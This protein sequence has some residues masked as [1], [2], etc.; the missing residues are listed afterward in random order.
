MIVSDSDFIRKQWQETLTRFK[1]DEDKWE[2]HTK[3][4][5]IQKCDDLAL[6]MIENKVLD[7]EIEGISSYLFKTINDFGISVS[8]RYIR[9]VIPENHTRKY[10]KSE[11]SSELDQSVYKKIETEDPEITLEK[12]QFNDIKINGVEYRPIIKKE[13]TTIK[14]TPTKEEPKT[15]FYTYL[16]AMRKLANKFELTQK[17]L[18]DRYRNDPEARK[19][20]E[21]ELGDVEKKLQDYAQMWANIENAK[22]MIDLRRHYGEYEKIMAAFMMETGET[23]AKMAQVMEYNNVYGRVK[24]YSEKYGSI[25][26]LREPRVREFFE[27]PYTY[28]LFLRSCPKCMED[29]SPLMNRNIEYYR[30]CQSQGIEYKP[31]YIEIPTIK[32]SF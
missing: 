3:A 12:D 13:P 5:Y 10:L 27:K 20:I 6:A 23:I 29:I 17:S 11:V 19:I 32:Y 25:G 31:L 2:N 26:I 14:E 9:D 7:L 15:R 1:D 22:G 16:E 28:P 8:D 21:K 30:E 4:E 18:K 24:H